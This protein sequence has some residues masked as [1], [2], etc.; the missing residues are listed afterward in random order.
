MQKPSKK[1]EKDV[2]NVKSK[3]KKSSSSLLSFS[4]GRDKENAILCYLRKHWKTSKKNIDEIH[5]A[6]KNEIC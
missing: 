4:L 3:S 2:K 5:F 6:I 1:V